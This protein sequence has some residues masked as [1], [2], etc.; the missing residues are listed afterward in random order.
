MRDDELIELDALLASPAFRNE[1]M[2]VVELQGLFCAIASGPENVEEETWL[3]FALGEEPQYETPEQEQRVAEL[4]RRYYDDTVQ[5]LASGEPLRLVL[6][7]QSDEALQESYEAWAG[8]Y[9]DGM[10]LSEDEWFDYAESDEEADFLVT[11]LFPIDVLSGLAAEEAED[12]GE[13]WPPEGTSED[14]LHAEAQAQLPESAVALYRF[15]QAKRPP[16]TIRRE[17]D[18][19]GRNDPCP[20]GSGKKYKQCC[21]LD[22]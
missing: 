11:H 5:A 19:I 12:L 6:A 9:L 14:E 4:M 7:N 17:G 21:G 13:T 10:E 20:C 15:W 16:A 2:S 18:K 22:A 1:A 8:G 3:P